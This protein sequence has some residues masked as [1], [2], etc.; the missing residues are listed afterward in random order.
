[1][2]SDVEVKTKLFTP[3]RHRWYSGASIHPKSIFLPSFLPLLPKLK[4]KIGFL[5]HILAK[6]IQCYNI[7]V[8]CLTPWASR[9]GRKFCLA[10]IQW[11]FGVL[12]VMLT[13]HTSLFRS[14]PA[15]EHPIHQLQCMRPIAFV[16]QKYEYFSGAYLVLVAPPSQSTWEQ[17]E[18]ISLI[19][20]PFVF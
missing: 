20:I 1:M 19:P 11:F 12:P 10:G 6:N 18:C 15:D 13:F 3:P 2:M 9:P 5:F 8:I 16:N 7:G 14:D 4:P 17:L